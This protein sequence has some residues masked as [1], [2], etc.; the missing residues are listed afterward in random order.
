M[1]VIVA[2]IAFGMGVDKPDVRLVVHTSLPKSVESYY[3]ETGRAGRDGLP[4]ECVLLYS[5]G[6]KVR[7]EFFIRRMEDEGER[8]NAQAKLDQMVR[9]AQLHSCRRRYLLEYF[10]EQW[11]VEDCG[12]CDVCLA[13]RERGE[14]DATEIAQKALSAV[15][16][17][18]EKYGETHVAGVLLGSRDKRILA[19]GHD[20]LSVYGIVKDFDRD[21]L[22]EVLGLLRAR[23]LLALNEGEYPTLRVTDEGRAFLQNRGQL[24]LP[25]L[26]AEGKASP[27]PKVSAGTPQEYDAGLFEELRVLR[28][29]LADAQDVPAF[30]VFGDVALRHMASA[31]PETLEAFAR[32]PGVGQAKL[33]AYGAAF[34]EAIRQYVDEHRLRAGA[35]VNAGGS[36]NGRRG[37]T[38]E[39]TWEML[40]RGLSVE[41]VARE[42][43]LATATV[44]RH[45]EV[46]T[47]H[48][49]SIDITSLL[50]SP[51]RR[52]DIEEAFKRLGY[53]QLGPVK[54]SLGDEYS[55]EDLTIARTWLR[56]QGRLP[57]VPLP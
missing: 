3:Q 11:D 12:G 53:A 47:M 28:R 51:E 5:Y 27:A 37:A 20:N 35:S 13:S 8:R 2:T 40:G 23:G 45:I 6:D 54:E 44:I 39:E 48:G 30:V 31:R 49:K 34:T 50:P 57:R 15:V 52:R 38:Y 1:P 43:G 9:F 55:Y 18:G 36:S 29:R 56:Q 25:R 4:S 33:A 32:I 7:Q 16:R 42:R 19:A 26:R 21:Q 24:L 14:F 41:A 10:G 17:T 22:R 46:L